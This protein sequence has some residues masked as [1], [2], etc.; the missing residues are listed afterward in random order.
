M[1]RPRRWESLPLGEHVLAECPRWD[2]VAGVLSWVDCVEGTL[3]AAALTDDGSWVLVSRHRLPWQVTAAVPDPTGHAGWWVA[4]GSGLVRVSPAGAVVG[5]VLPASTNYPAVRTNDMVLDPRGRLL[6]GLFAEDRRTPMASVR[7]VDPRD[8]TEHALVSGVVT[9][10]GLGLSPDRKS[11][12]VVDTARG[13]LSRHGYD[14]D[15]GYAG[16]GQVIV[17][18]PGP[19]VLDGLAV[20]SG[21][22]IWVAV[23]GA[24]AVHRYSPDGQLLEVIGTPVARPSAVA[25]VG[26]SEDL[27]VMTTARLDLTRTC[28][29]VPPCPDGR[30]YGC[31]VD[32]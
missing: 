19:G 14:V 28:G 5:T 7:S 9:A 21:G 6:V 20:D 11:L 1:T 18:W 25:L 12:Y 17:Q 32:R 2:P 13:T 16:T 31:R 15:T 24:S 4:N 10:N 26:P 22:H 8:G 30:L 3:S 29:E 23:W 27:L